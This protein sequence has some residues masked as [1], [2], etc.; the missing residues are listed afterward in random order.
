MKTIG[1]FVL[2]RM[3]KKEEQ[4]GIAV[5][6]RESNGSEGTVLQIGTKIRNKN[7]SP[8]VFEVKPGDVIGFDPT[9]LFPVDFDGPQDHRYMIK[10][11]DII[12]KYGE[13]HKG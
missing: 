11:S 3:H 6:G 8:F 1:E 5:V 7:G 9:R 13:D 4:G 12:Y 10:H 2:V